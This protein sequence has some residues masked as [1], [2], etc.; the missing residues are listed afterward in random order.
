MTGK[1]PYAENQD[2]AEIRHVKIFELLGI[3][4]VTEVSG[5]TVIEDVVTFFLKKDKG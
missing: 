5:N 1:S 3:K 2:C 4:G